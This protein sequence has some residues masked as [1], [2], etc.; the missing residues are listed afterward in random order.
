M[1]R[2]QRNNITDYGPGA[3]TFAHFHQ[4]HIGRCH[5]SLADLCVVLRQKAA[6]T[7]RHMYWPYSMLLKFMGLSAAESVKYTKTASL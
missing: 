5:Q 7:F 1:I 4:G 3:G 2:G 6:G